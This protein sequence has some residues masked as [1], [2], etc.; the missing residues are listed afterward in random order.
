MTYRNW[1][2]PR[3]TNTYIDKARSD[4]GSLLSGITKGFYAAELGAGSVETSSG[5]FI[6][7]CAKATG[8][9]NGN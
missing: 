1:P 9:R 7:R 2:L 6:S 3:M 5:N 4:P 8:S